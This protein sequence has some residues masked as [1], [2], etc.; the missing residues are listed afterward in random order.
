M[1]VNVHLDKQT[2]RCRSGATAPRREWVG[3]AFADGTTL[4]CDMVVVSAG[5]RPNASLAVEAGLTVE[6]GIV[7]TDELRCAGDANVFA[8]GECAQH[9]GQLYGLVAPLWEQAQ[10]RSPTGS[11]GRIARRDCITARESRPSSR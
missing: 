6:R 9:R 7:V 4:R 2:T 8:I 11:T 3:S 10:R 5:I 1:G